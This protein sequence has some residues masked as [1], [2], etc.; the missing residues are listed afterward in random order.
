[1]IRGGLGLVVIALACTACGDDPMDEPS[2]VSEVAAATHVLAEAS[3]GPVKAT[4][5]TDATSPRFG[6]RFQIVLEIVH[7]PRVRLEPVEFTDRIGHFRRVGR[8][9]PPRTES[10]PVVYGLRV[11]PERT[12]TNIGTLPPVVFEILEGEGAGTVHALRVPTFEMEVAGLT[13]DE[14]P[15]LADVGDPLPPV[16][17][18]ARERGMLTLWVALAGGAVLLV[19][20]G[21]VWWQRR[22]RTTWTP[23]PID[24]RAEARRALEELIAKRLVEIGAFGIF[25][26]ELTGIVRLFIERTTGVQAPDQTTEEFLREVEGHEAFPADRRHALARFLE[27]ADLVKYAA[28][29]PGRVEIDEA[30]DA[31]YTFCGLKTEQ[32]EAC[33]PSA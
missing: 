15:S 6:D 31:A 17:L 8:R 28:Q 25:Y 32:A 1:M 4:V 22:R 10:G 19:L 16:P 24:P 26:V 20:T 29:V 2:I 9:D 33:A 7:G 21:F 12:G 18:P 13:E 23:P 27:A 14:K 11:E 30:V 3:L 5:R